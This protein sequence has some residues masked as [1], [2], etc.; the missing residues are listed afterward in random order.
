MISVKTLTT[1]ILS[2]VPSDLYDAEGELANLSRIL[3][4]MDSILKHRLQTKFPLLEEHFTKAIEI[5]EAI[6]EIGVDSTDIDDRIAVLQDVYTKVQK[7]LGKEAKKHAKQ[8]AKRS[9]KRSKKNLVGIPNKES[10][11]KSIENIREQ[12]APQ[13]SMEIPVQTILDPAPDAID[14]IPLGD[15]SESNTQEIPPYFSKWTTFKSAISKGALNGSEYIAEK[16]VL[17]WQWLRARSS[18][19][20]VFGARTLGSFS[21]TIFA[22]LTGFGLAAGW[23]APGLALTFVI[24]VSLFAGAELFGIIRA[25][26]SKRNPGE[27]I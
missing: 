27:A 13:P 4:E 20:V 25:I 24:S 17:G 22:I 12:T 9:S 21:A 19:E 18:D 1:E 7:S 3:A 26:I 14:V 10:C 11:N 5:S 23:N 16:I 8:S 2:R 6:Q 15:D